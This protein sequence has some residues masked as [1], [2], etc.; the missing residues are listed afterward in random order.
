MNFDFS[1]E[2]QELRRQAQRLL[3]TG[4]ARARTQVTASASF[5]AALWRQAVE[6]GWTAAAVPEAQGGLGLG[7]LEL[8]VLAEECGRALAPLP[9]AA[10]V[11]QATQALSITQSTWP[12]DAAAAQWLPLLAAGEV[13]ATVA[14]VEPGG[15][16]WSDAPQ[17]RVQGG[18]L[19]G[20]KSPVAQAAG[21][22]LAIVSARSDEDGDSFGL[23]LVDLRGGGTGDE[24][25]SRSDIH[26]P[27]IHSLD[28]VNRHGGLRFDGAPAQ[29]LGPP[30][31]G[32]EL[33]RRLIDSTA[34]LMA[35]EQLGS[36]E[37]A[38]AMALAYV[39]Q[40]KAFGRE[41]ASYQAV[42]HRLADMYVKNQ[43][44][45]SHA[46]YGAW[47]LSTGAAELP[48]AA[49]GAR[50]AALDAQT[51]ATE[52]NVQLHGGIG[53]TWECDAQLYYRRTR[54]QAIAL[55]GRAHW[56]QRLV[57]MLAR[58][59]GNTTTAAATSA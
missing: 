19:T 38:L 4:C 15:R 20:T 7:V 39:R 5:D 37:A 13:V 27:S 57:A 49:A 59:D 11:L 32:P 6:M 35:F 23:W 42:K 25:G 52:E 26:R 28:L 33:L 17:A 10:S 47:A 30:G 41:I 12:N 44:A 8:C 1:D 31:A 29:R 53:F 21:A 58:V 43:L 45:R 9:F 56:A 54:A 46:Y 18:R 50:L 36:A 22:D 2:Q 40:R 14:L 16:L 48:L 3:G 55:G 34:V 24:A 51:F